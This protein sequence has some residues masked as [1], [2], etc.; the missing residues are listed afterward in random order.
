[1]RWVLDV[2]EDGT[3]TF[4]PELLE[5]NGWKEGDVLV[6]KDNGDGS[7]TLSKKLDNDNEKSV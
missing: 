7:W 5:A 3:L 6:W 2:E 1:M 4:P